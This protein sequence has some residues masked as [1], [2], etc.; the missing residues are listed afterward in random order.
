MALLATVVRRALAS[1]DDPS[2]KDAAAG[3]LAVTYAKAIDEANVVAASLSKVLREVAELDGDVYDRLLPLAV[4]IERTHVLAT[5]GPKLLATMDA[6]L[7]TPK[8]R[9]ALQKGVKDAGKRRNPLS[10]L[11]AR[12]AARVDN[13]QAVDPT[14]PGA[15][16]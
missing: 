7:I 10:E 5:L 16:T 3:A 13:A 15:D 14:A 4:R 6:L 11:R 12:R 2:P 1:I 8:A 9:S